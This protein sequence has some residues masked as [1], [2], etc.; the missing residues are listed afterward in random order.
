MKDILW[1][2]RNTL[3][4]TFHNKK[5]IILYVCMPLAGII[6]SFLA[7]GNS[8]QPALHVGIVNHDQGYI[9]TDAIKFIS[10]LE[11]VQVSRV[12]ASDVNN[13][14]TSK[15]L[16]CAITFP[17]GFSQRVQAGKP[18][19][20]QLISIRGQEITGFVNFYLNQYIDNITALSKAA[21]GDQNTFEKMYSHYQHSSFKLATMILKDTSKNKEMTNQT[22]G[23]LIMIMLFSAVSLS[24]IILKDKENRTYFRLLSTP[25][26]A[27]KYVFSNI[28]VNMLVMT[29]QVTLTIVFMTEVFHIEIGMPSW[30]MA[31]IL[32]FFALVSV[33]LSLMLVSFVSTSTSAS[34][35][36]NLIV[37]P[38][39][40]LAGCFWPVEI[41]PTSVQ[42][43]ADFLP[44]HWALDAISQLQQGH[45]FAS[46]SMNFML[47]F[48]FAGAFFLIAVY[49]F[50]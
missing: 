23:F 22:L 44:Q 20:V 36:Q 11:N 34:A 19:P 35:L 14:I 33:G 26:D 21:K 24:E 16:D 38:T 41:M 13:Q 5:S 48:A 3:R 43:I 27:K 2:I 10:G 42:K 6:F 50:K 8:V 49:K 37:T 32:M 4:V 28:V 17:A 31:V 7:Y 29:L 39:C 18:I 1:L 47:L 12:E 30:Q 46:L 9:T 45:Q 15:T 40:M 25:I